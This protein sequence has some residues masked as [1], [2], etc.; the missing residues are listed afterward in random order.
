MKNDW[1][2]RAWLFALMIALGLSGAL[3]AHAGLAEGTAAYQTEDYATALAEWL[4]LAE[5]G[6]GSA[7]YYLGVMYLHG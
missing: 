2:N 5:G 1:Q 4:P 3:P 7:Q 6:D